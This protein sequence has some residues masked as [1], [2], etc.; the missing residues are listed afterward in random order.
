MSITE[1]SIKRP[2]LVIV[3]FTILMLLGAFGYT[4]LNYE[5]L[6]K[7]TPPVITITTVYPGASPSEV[8][9]SVTKVL[10]D[11]VSGLDKVDA[12]YAQSQEG[13]SLLTVN[14]EQSADID[15]A[16]SDAQREI[17]Q[18]QSR[19]PDGIKAPI[20][21][22]FALDEF[23]VLRVA[24]TGT[25]PGT[26][27]YQLLKD[28]VQPRLARL[29]GVG[30]VTLIGGEER[31]IRIALD[32]QKIRAN[33]LSI[34]QVT[35]AIKSANLDIPTGKVNDTDGEYIVRLAGKFASVDDLRTLVVAEA[36]DGSRIHLAEIAEVH[37]GTKEIA[38]YSRLNGVDAV[39]VQIFK[40]SDANQ[41]EVSRLARAELVNLEQDFKAIGLKADIAQDG[42]TFTVDAANAVKQD[43]S[44]AILLVALVMLAFLHS[45]RNS[46]IVMVAIPAS[47]I[48]TIFAMFLLGYT[49][50][51]MTLLA[52]SLVIGIL[53]D[54][55]IV[56]LENIYHHMEK[57]EDRRQ[58][59]VTGRSEIGFAALAITLVDVAVFVPLIMVTGI[60][61][62]IMRQFAAVVVVST[63]LSLLVSFTLTPMLAS[64]FA[65]LQPLT[66]KSV[67][68]RIGLFFEAM[69]DRFAN[70]YSGILHWSLR[71]R[72][73]VGIATL[74]MFFASVALVPL[75]FIGGEFITKSDRGEFSV[76]V[77]LPL[78]TPV[79][80]TNRLTRDIEERLAAVPEVRKLLTNVGTSSEGWIGLTSPHAAEV[81]VTLAARSERERTTAEIA[82]EI[83][84]IVRSFPGVKV[85]VNEIGIFGTA[86]QSPIQ[87]VVNGTDYDEVRAGAE[88]LA[89]VVRHVPGATDVRLSSEDGK[90]E[91]RID[92][93]RE[94]MAA[95]GLSVAEVGQT[96]RVALDGDDDS[97][98]RD[99]PNDFG[100][101]IQLDSYDRSRTA[102]LANLT[103]FNRSGQQIELQQFATIQQ[104]SGPTKLLRRDRN[105]G[106]TVLA[107]STGRP[108]GSIG[109][110]V[111]TALKSN[112]LPAGVGMAYEADLKMQQE[113][114]SSLGMAF[115]AGIVF[116]YLI[117]V[118]LYN[119]WIYPFVVLFSIPVAMIGALLAL[120]LTMKSLSIFSMLGIIMLIGLVGKNAILL[121][122]RANV[123][124][125]SGMPTFAAL[126]EAGKTRLRPIVMTTI[127]M[128]LGMVP[129]ALHSSAGA[130]WKSGL[131]AALIGGLTSSLLLTLVL[132]P[133]VYI[134][135]DQWRESVPAFF[136]RLFG[137]RIAV[138]P[139]RVAV[140]AEHTSVSA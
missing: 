130:E 100:I 45:V 102:N 55:S 1:L 39:T 106:I 75:G 137:R 56:V 131:A 123:N 108:I 5:L 124:K 81:N 116:T 24:M 70:H 119:S 82:R 42:S 50:N 2:T 97:K 33:N 61:G 25:L 47:L 85:R 64:R 3:G 129:L 44:V 73:T 67:M 122:D 112:P 6:P 89:T 84:A 74:V 139:I 83:K 11:A 125:A 43:L 138:R 60:V 103:F 127:A 104:T 109:Q 113:S 121:V 54:D 101:R 98:F 53:V 95:L 94:K 15:K 18:V 34:L 72:K 58:A 114:N 7:I 62:N 29:A 65:I 79:E 16:L 31:E 134:K 135:V 35:Q 76:T 118:A 32:A 4:Q 66:A 78:G 52:M 48:S 30:Q 126:M 22:R 57:G 49:L 28:K 107:N 90:P 69:Y 115:L 71:H 27:F 68:G 140:A 80:E 37:D 92:F 87:L 46:L 26:Q 36:R 23:P 86:D 93:D 14:F 120:A 128:I 96:L 132:V 8:E 40:Q 111:A 136:G 105:Y 20:I 19:L 41:L 63:L 13:A 133:V 38:T 17:S 77:E 51:L 21:D 59:S 88:H 9:N 117:M 110:D 12:L 10:E 91:T 99:G